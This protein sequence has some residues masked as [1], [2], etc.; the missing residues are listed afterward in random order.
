MTSELALHL[1][2][3]G[4]HEHFVVVAHADGIDHAAV[5]LRGLDVAQALAAAILRTVTGAGADL[6]FLVGFAVIWT[7]LRILCPWLGLM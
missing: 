6:A 7:A 4:N 3:G 2:F 5:A 1:A